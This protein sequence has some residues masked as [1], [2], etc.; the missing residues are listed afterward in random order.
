MNKAVW[1]L[2]AVIAVVVCFHAF[3]SLP[4]GFIR[5]KIYPGNMGESVVA[6]RGKDSV[7]TRSNNGVFVMTLKPG[8][9]KIIVSGKEQTRNIVRENLIVNQGQ[10][11]NLGE[12][13]LTE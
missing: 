11:I 4:T 8:N 9:W 6:V 2:S 3:R 7:K 10:W 1:E 5:G 12:I 13:R